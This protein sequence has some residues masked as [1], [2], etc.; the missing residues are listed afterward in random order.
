[1]DLFRS[2][3]RD[4]DQASLEVGVGLQKKHHGLSG[5]LN[6]LLD[7]GKDDEDGLGTASENTAS[8]SED[9]DNDI[10]KASKKQ[11]AFAKISIKRE[12]RKEKEQRKKTEKNLISMDDFLGKQ[13]EFK[14]WLY[15]EK[16]KNAG[17]MVSPKL[18]AHFKQFVRLWNKKKLASKYYRCSTL[19]ES[20]AP[21]TPKKFNFLSEE[22]DA[23]GSPLLADQDNDIAEKDVPTSP[24]VTFGK[25][26]PKVF[27]SKKFQLFGSSS[28]EVALLSIAPIG[29]PQV[30]QNEKENI[31]KEQYQVPKF[32]KKKDTSDDG[33]K[34]PRGATPYKVSVFPWA[35]RDIKEVDHTDKFNI[36][37]T[38]TPPSMSHKELE[39]EESW[40]SPPSETELLGDHLKPT[41]DSPNVPPPP[42]PRLE[43]LQ[44][45][46]CVTKSLKLAG[47][48]SD[49]YDKLPDTQSSKRLVCS[50][51]QDPVDCVQ[52]VKQRTIPE[53]ARLV[54]QNLS[55][56]DEPDLSL[57]CKP[58]SEKRFS[59]EELEELYAKPLKR[60]KRNDIGSLSESS[61]KPDQKPEE[62]SDL[63]NEIMDHINKSSSEDSGKLASFKPDPDYETIDEC[64]AKTERKTFEDQKDFDGAADETKKVIDLPHKSEDGSVQKFATISRSKKMRV[65]AASTEKIY[66][67]YLSLGRSANPYKNKMDIPKLPEPSAEFKTGTFTQSLKLKS[68]SQPDISFSEGFQAFEIDMNKDQD[69][70][71]S[72]PQMSSFKPV[73]N[74]RSTQKNI[75]DVKLKDSDRAKSYEDGLRYIEEPRTPIIMATPSFDSLCNV[76]PLSCKS[77]SSQSLPNKSGSYESLSADSHMSTSTSSSL[78]FGPD[79]KSGSVQSLQSEK[80]LSPVKEEDEFDQCL[81]MKNERNS[82]E[83]ELKERKGKKCPLKTE[84]AGVVNK[85]HM[86][87]NIEGTVDV[88]N[89]EYE[90][91]AKTDLIPLTPGKI[92]ALKH[93]I[94]L[95][96]YLLKPAKQDD[97]EKENVSESEKSSQQTTDHNAGKPKR[98]VESHCSQKLFDTQARL[99]IKDRLS[100]VKTKVDQA[101][102][103]IRKETERRHTVQ[104]V[105]EITARSED[106]RFIQNASDTRKD[107]TVKLGKSKF[108]QGANGRFDGSHEPDSKRHCGEKKRGMS[109]DDHY[110]ETDLDKVITDKTR[111]PMKKSKSH[112]GFET[113]SSAVVTEIW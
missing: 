11:K 52:I 33:Q 41:N 22:V 96:V 50:D 84:N 49:P 8:E 61:A 66:E 97:R 86:R 104:T 67:T 80:S 75:G 56:N 82:N 1:M 16:S 53:D 105:Q 51:Y 6:D 12:K 106:N 31:S 99:A 17:E 71:C 5:S 36:C 44:K 3:K 25:T 54:L 43:S 9:E 64:L 24:F 18:K 98:M 40:P 58:V 19:P 14:M 70:M 39:E 110:L 2:K 85:D 112:S 95:S 7:I 60:A 20:P 62:Q 74:D 89:S 55:G 13:T 83:N 15:E 79:E 78:S 35:S 45:T 63:L 76:T 81:N 59:K 30:V 34:M 90:A 23:G 107:E 113:G 48:Y 87:T 108:Y 111:K 103:T 65:M 72:V 46:D 69:Q 38:A 91:K 94:D 68:K 109:V 4:V 42:P 57:Y 88:A 101:K 100:G 10:N 47:N 93:G 28:K 102:T 37:P 27:R 73:E 77:F 26:P 92:S 32:G 21:L 29:S